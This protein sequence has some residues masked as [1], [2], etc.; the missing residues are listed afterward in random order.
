MI[1][2][3]LSKERA[4]VLIVGETG[5]GKTTVLAEAIRV[6]ELEPDDEGRRTRKR[7][8]W[9]TGAGRIVAGMKY[10]GQWEE[11]CES[12]IEELG[13]IQGTLCVENLLELIRQGGDTPQDSIASF[14]LPYLQRGELHMVG[15][16]T[17]AEL[18]ACRR[19]L[20]GFADVFRILPLEPMTRPQALG[21]LDRLSTMLK[22]NSH[23]EPTPGTIESIH[24]LFHRFL[25]YEAFPGPAARFVAQL[26]ETARQK[27]RKTVSADDVLALFTRQTGLPEMLLRDD[28]P[29]TQTE[30]R[31][32][33]AARV[34]G[35]SAAV[36]EATSSSSRSRQDSTIRSGRS[37]SCSSA[38]R[39]ASARRSSL[40]LLPTSSLSTAT[41]RTG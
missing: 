17:P 32:D 26:F 9:L 27:K 7:C 16:A 20:P 34:I 4:N 5:S 19:L 25:P 23:I 28:W 24:H 29:L 31:T 37:E 6:V 15:E 39:P 12:M 21:V 14:L 41:R 8:H 1:A 22:Q 11:R 30:V 3:R 35:Q 38:G 36:D 18:D 13:R 40:G 33:L 10:L 2:G